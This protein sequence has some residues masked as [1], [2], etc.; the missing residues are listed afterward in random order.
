MAENKEIPYWIADHDMEILINSLRSQAKKL[1]A[2][3]DILA[4][5]LKMKTAT[6]TTGLGMEG[7]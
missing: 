4:K 1:N 6:L 5:K 2:M 7:R 3:A